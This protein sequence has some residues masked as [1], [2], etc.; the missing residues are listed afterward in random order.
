MRSEFKMCTDTEKLARRREDF[1][2][3]KLLGGM[4]SLKF[5]EDEKRETRNESAAYMKLIASRK[6]RGRQCLVE[7]T[8]VVVGANLRSLQG[9]TT[10]L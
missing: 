6:S 1:G 2:V 5:N 3:R 7:G 4:K 10:V 9:S 8:M